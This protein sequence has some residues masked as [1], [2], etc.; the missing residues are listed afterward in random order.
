MAYKKGF[1]A[2]PFMLVHTRRLSCNVAREGPLRRYSKMLESGILKPD[3]NQ[4]VAVQKLQELYNDLL[5]YNPS[6]RPN[7]A[8]SETVRL[9]KCTISS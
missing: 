6:P 3:K 5:E 2:L 8:P 1:T 7:Q 9:S 4:F